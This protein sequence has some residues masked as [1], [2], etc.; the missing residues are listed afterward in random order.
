M[1][2]ISKTHPLY[3]VLQWTLFPLIMFGPLFIAA[4]LLSNGLSEAAVAYG[5]VLSIGLTIWFFERVMPYRAHWNRADADRTTDVVSGGIAYFLLPLVLK[6]LF[7][8]LMVT[9]TIFLASQ[10]GSDLWPDDWPLWAQLILGLLAI[11]AGRYWGHRLCH[12][13]SWLWRFHANHHSPNRL[14]WFNAL[15]C[16]PVERFVFL[17]SEML[18]PVLLGAN[19]EVL[20]LMQIVTATNGFCQHTNMDVK[21][22]WF[23]YIFNTVDLHRWH[24][25]KDE[26]ESNANYGNNLIIYDLLF[27]TYYRPKNREVGEIGLVNPNYPKDYRGQF[28]APFR[29]GKLDKEVGRTK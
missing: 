12:E 6:P 15:R 27:G 7:A 24:H 3:L 18:F 22:G 4:A 25:S 14:W 2:T 28:M 1:K 8:A 29:R 13:V 19:D 21:L 16:H 26:N 10:F 20:V 11:D 23:Y 9:A 5:M 17:F